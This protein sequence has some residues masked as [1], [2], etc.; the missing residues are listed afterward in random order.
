MKTSYLLFT[1]ILTFI[2]ILISC[3]EDNDLQHTFNPD[4][5]IDDFD[6]FEEAIPFDQTRY[7]EALN[8]D[9][10]AGLG[11]ILFY[12][13]RLSQNNSMACASCHHQERG[14]SDKT[15]FSTGLLNY[16]TTRNSMTLVN[17]AYQVSHF[18]E[19]HRG[20]MENH[21]LSPISNHIEMGMKDINALVEK[22]K[23][24]EAYDNLFKEVYNQEINEELIANSLTIFVASIV[25]YNSK[26]DK[27]KENDFVNF[28]NTEK[29]G[30]N[31]FFGKAKCSSC[32]KGDHFA[33]RWRSHANIGLDEVYE[34][35]GAEDGKFKVPSLRNI[36]LTG[37]Y[38]HDGRFATL[39][40]VVDHYVN[41]IQ[42]HPSL[43][44]ILEDP[45]SLTDLEQS[46][47]IEFLHTLTD[48]ELI[49][50]EKFS[51]PFR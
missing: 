5:T 51:N 23:K 35:Q 50:D 37:P 16:E 26:F 41:G 31:L 33:A 15:P 47:L 42:D 18:W 2:I 17:N 29:R 22:L 20:R 46:E 10:I 7:G 38:M 21:I 32:H 25:S 34:D 11:R 19:G 45:I 4:L 40:E 43:D 44:W 12:D 8:H 13:S 27:G 36:A 28:T 6:Y 30:K 3:Q 48:Y 39:D 14:F 24:I 1:L 9:Q 49:S